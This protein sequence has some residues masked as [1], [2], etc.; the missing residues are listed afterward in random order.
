VGTDGPSPHLLTGVDVA[1]KKG[2]VT[3]KLSGELSNVAALTVDVGR[4]GLSDSPNLDIK[5][6]RKVTITFVRG[7]TVVG[8]AT[9]PS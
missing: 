2:A 7:G 9:V 6:D 1:F 3:D 8:T 5:A 4:A